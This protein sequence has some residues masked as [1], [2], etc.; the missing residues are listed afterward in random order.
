MRGMSPVLKWCAMMKK[1]SGFAAVMALLFM[2]QA[3]MGVKSEEAAVTASPTSSST[4]PSPTSPSTPAASSDARP[5]TTTSRRGTVNP[6]LVKAA[7]CMRSRGWTVPDPQPGDMV[8]AP[9]NV[10]P[11]DAARANKD[12]EECAKD[13]YDPF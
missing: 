4:V 2:L 10:S 5:R 1:V 8:V 13:A 11:A 6:S 12:A 9:K 3:C 7:K